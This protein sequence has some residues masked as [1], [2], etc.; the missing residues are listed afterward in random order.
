[1]FR[2][3]FISIFFSFFFFFIGLHFQ[4]M[5]VPGLGGQLELQLLANTTATATPDLSH[6]CDLHQ[7]LWQHWILKPPSESRDRSRILTGLW[8]FHLISHYENSQFYFIL[9]NTDKNNLGL[10]QSYIHVI[11]SL[12]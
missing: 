12:E 6:I 8:D 10:N 7:S 4:H 2:F 1:M 9:S 3:V 5:E 11:I